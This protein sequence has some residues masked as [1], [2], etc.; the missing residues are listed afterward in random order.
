MA[1]VTLWGATY[2]DVPAIDLPSGN[3]TVRFY[4]QTSND[5][6]VTLSWDDDYYGQGEGAWVPNRTV[7]EI[8]DAYESERNI[9]FVGEYGNPVNWFYDDDYVFVYDIFDGSDPSVP[10]SLI[11]K[12]Y[13]YTT[14]GI[15]YAGDTLLIFPN[16]DSPSVTYTPTTQTQ[17]DTITYNRQDSYNGIEEVT[18]TIEAMPTGTAGTPTATKGTVSNHSIPVTP[19]VTNTSGYIDGG[20]KTGTAVTVAAILTTILSVLGACAYTI[21]QESDR[22]SVEIMTLIR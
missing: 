11:T 14:D 3:G 6:V 1:Q 2:N 20:T 10:N 12:G 13:V 21:R 5:F 7:Y 15:E 9:I 19:S 22:K 4:E 18:V 8:Q 16:F 17:T